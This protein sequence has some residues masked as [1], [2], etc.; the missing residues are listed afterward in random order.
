[1][2]H[3]VTCRPS[4]KI[5]RVA[6]VWALGGHRKSAVRVSFV[7]GAAVPASAP[8]RRPREV[9]MLH[10]F[11][12]GGLLLHHSTLRPQPIGVLQHCM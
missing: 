1:V 5:D 9:G 12:G 3:R 2:C 10:S 11:F 4:P 6:V 8:K 7:T